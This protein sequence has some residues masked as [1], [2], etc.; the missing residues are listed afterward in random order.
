MDMLLPNDHCQDSCSKL[1]IYAPIL[2]FD[3]STDPEV[4][5][6]RVVRGLHCIASIETLYGH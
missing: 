2:A 3:Q 5:Y 4:Y 1:P 6:T